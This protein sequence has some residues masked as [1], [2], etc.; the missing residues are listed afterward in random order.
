MR[1]R[2]RVEKQIFFT[3][4]CHNIWKVTKFY[5]CQLLLVAPVYSMYEHIHTVS[6]QISVSRA[7]CSSS[8]WRIN[9]E[10]K[11]RSWGDYAWKIS[12]FSSRVCCIA[13]VLARLTPRRQFCAAAAAALSCLDVK[14]EKSLLSLKWSDVNTFLRL[15][16]FSI[17]STFHRLLP[18]QAY[19]IFLTLHNIFL[20]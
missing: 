16:Y 19:A 6:K 3:S 2:K 20:Y 9:C 1:K 12:F 18:L 11:K 17:H 7:S 15:L 13:C 14:R 10:T 8:C 5:C 4:R